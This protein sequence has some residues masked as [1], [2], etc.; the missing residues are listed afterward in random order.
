MQSKIVS[1]V[2]RARY[3][4]RTVTTTRYYSAQAAPVNEGKD[5][6]WD[7][8]LPY[9]KIPRMT[10]RQALK[11]FAP[12]GRYHNASAPEI[13]RLC[14]QDFGDLVRFPG[15]LGR[16]DTVMTFL[17][18]DF[19]K[20]FRTEGPWPNRRG[21]ATFVHYR[22][23]VRPD[24]FKG[25]GGLVSEQGENWQKFRS[26]VNPVLLQPKV[27]RSY[28]GKLD[29]VTSEFMNIMLKI[30]DKRN[31]LPADFGQWLNRWSLES[32]GVLSVDSR[33]GVLDEQ[34]SEEA[35]RIVQ[36]TKELF[37]LVYQLDILP[38]IWRYYKTPK[39]HRLMKVFDELTTI[40][41]SKVD[42]AVLRLEK[43]P[44]TTSDAQS[45][46]EKLL[47]IDRNVAIVMS[48]DMILA[49]V[50]TVSVTLFQANHR[51]NDKIKLQTTSA[52][53]GILYY[54]ATNPEKQT[55]LREELRSI[56]PQKD[57]PLTP[58]N[59]Q[60]LPYLRACIKEG[61]RLFP[62]IPLT[63]DNMQNLP[64]LRACIKEGMRLFPPII[65]NLRVTG[66]DIVLQ[67]YRIPKGT[68]IG[69]G[70]MVVQQSDR[71]VPRAKEFLPERWLKPPEPGCPHAKDAHPFVY[72][73]FGNGPRTCVGRRLAMLEMEILIARIT[74]LFEYRWNYGD[75][76]IQTTLVNT[77]VNDLKFQM[78]E[79]DD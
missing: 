72:L 58:D 24:V 38:S 32:T 54:L 1:N 4:G 44:S 41:M 67:G 64:Y 56:L 17:P 61:M 16:K 13:H 59:M 27:V 5:P 63:P 68:D 66:K 29:E 23:E 52:I 34:E 73:P 49:G 50:D 48:F 78:V 62:P 65:G 43:S 21:L 74:R 39:Y 42:E 76:K 53:T 70:S 45:V 28:V 55:K 15:I 31:E 46:L 9:E 57:S 60:N 40:A 79:V 10:L 51:P 18:D 75:L 11:N 2:L 36:L 20:V 35:R 6:E 22:K 69:M 8:A 7:S 77:P 37:E 71:F 47:K 19:E 12:G 14:Q 25:L 26:I 33:L 3:Y 30:R